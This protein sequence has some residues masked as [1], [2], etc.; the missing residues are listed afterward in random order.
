MTG[1]YLIMDRGSAGPVWI[2]CMIPKNGL[3]PQNNGSLNGRLATSSS[4]MQSAR[5][6]LERRKRIF[7]PEC[8][9]IGSSWVPC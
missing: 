7:G 9:F 2:M 1:D 6:I 4:A 5:R 3:K 8:R